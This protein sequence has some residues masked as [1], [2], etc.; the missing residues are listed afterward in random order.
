VLLV[1]DDASMRRALSRTIGLAGFEVETFSSAE[2]LLARGVRPSDACLVLDVD[3][4]G[5]DGIACKRTLD[6]GGGRSL[7]TVFVTALAPADVGDALAGLGATT[8]LYKPFDQAALL[9]AITRAC[10]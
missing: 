7:P 2:L 8:V 9:E 3:L 5:M 10:H 1:D 6:A 4:P